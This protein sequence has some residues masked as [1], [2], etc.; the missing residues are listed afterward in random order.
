MKL[1]LWAWEKITMNIIWGK[2][3]S[4]IMPNWGLCWKLWEAKVFLNGAL[5]KAELSESRMAYLRGSEFL[6][7]QKYKWKLNDHLPRGT[8]SQIRCLSNLLILIVHNSIRP[9]GIL[10]FLTLQMKMGGGRRWETNMCWEPLLCPCALTHMIDLKNKDQTDWVIHLRLLSN[11]VAESELEPRSSDPKC[12][13]SPLN[14]PFLFD[15]PS[16]WTLMWSMRARIVMAES[17]GRCSAEGVPTE[18][19]QASSLHCLAPWD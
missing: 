18:Q 13:L 5:S 3:T 1:W 12:R 9:Q 16:E 11:R 4:H 10:K 17:Q 6:I 19:V 7:I 8:R 15:T 14:H 2:G